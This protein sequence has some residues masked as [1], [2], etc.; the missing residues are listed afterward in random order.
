MTVHNGHLI[1][2][3][4]DHSSSQCLI[5][6]PIFG[7]TTPFS[8]EIPKTPNQWI[9][10]CFCNWHNVK[11]MGCLKFQMVLIRKNA[12][13]S[14]Q[15]YRQL[16][17]EIPKPLSVNVGCSY[18]EKHSFTGSIACPL[19]SPGYYRLKVMQDHIPKGKPPKS[20]K[21][22]LLIL[23]GSSS[24]PDCSIQCNY[25]LCVDTCVVRCT[26]WLRGI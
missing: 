6:T 17:I 24:F 22:C 19:F 14:F 3:T 9:I 1:R 16:P 23:S 21:S 10:L 5:S 12:T 4:S 7:T 20:R 26:I 15:K 13:R 25:R 8:D 2:K 11:I 18:H